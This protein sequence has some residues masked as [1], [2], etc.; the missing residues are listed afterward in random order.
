MCFISIFYDLCRT[1]EGHPP[2][3]FAIATEETADVHVSKCPCFLISGNSQGIT[4]EDMW[5]EIKKVG[6]TSTLL[7]VV[8]QF[9]AF[10]LI[11]NS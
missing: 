1:A 4:A 10:L 5:H 3:T 9:M 11:S 6:Y 8:K 7:Y 2:V